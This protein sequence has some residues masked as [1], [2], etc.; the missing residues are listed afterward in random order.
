V[1]DGKNATVIY[2]YPFSYLEYRKQSR[3][4]VSNW[5]KKTGID[6]MGEMFDLCPSCGKHRPAHLTA[7][8]GER[9]TEDHAKRCSGHPRSYV[10]GYEFSADALVLPVPKQLIPDNEIEAFCRTL[11]TA[12]VAGAAELLELE[13]DEIAFF[14][15]PEPG[16]GAIITFYETVPGGAGYLASLASRL[17]EWAKV[18]VDRLFAHE[19]SGACYGCLKSYRNQPFHHLLDKNLVR[20][21]LFQLSTHELLKQPF[22]AKPNEGIKLA[23]RWIEENAPASAGTPTKDTVIERRLFEAIAKVG[24]L[25]EP[26]K[27]REFRSGEVLI[28]VADFAYESEKIAIYCDGFAFH[29]TAEKLAADANKRNHLQSQGWVVLTFWGQTILRNPERCEEQIWRA[30][31]H[32]KAE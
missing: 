11:G 15:H 16:A 8:E 12:L 31:C 13:S 27:Q 3:I 29:G 1:R 14:H 25:P 2:P 18:S 28:T 6:G 23:N 9:W 10:L 22:D 24:R 7:K 20:D 17:P 19:C 26:V 5:G 32:R 4:L 30:F 21:A